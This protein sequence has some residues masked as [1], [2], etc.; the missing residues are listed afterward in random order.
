MSTNR[1]ALRYAKALLLEADQQN[2]APAVKQDMLSVF[3]TIEESKEL[4]VALSSPVIK[5]SDK[6][7]VLLQVFNKQSELTK[8]LIQVLA[9]NQ[10]TDLLNEVAEAY[11]S[12]FN[13]R[14]G[15][16]EVTVTTAIALSSELEKKVLDK[17]KELTQAKEVILS[18]KI[19]ES[20]LGGFII[21]FG[22]LQY[23]ASVAN[24][25]KTI[26]REFS[27]RL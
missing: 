16:K 14:E 25:L 12:I 4:Q 26:K 21:R 27:K 5:T 10:R 3:Q 9:I 11:I 1:A 15:I 13:D 6:R 24:Q 17:A 19:D 18:S 2:I 23:D 20:I 8:G 7:D 22:D